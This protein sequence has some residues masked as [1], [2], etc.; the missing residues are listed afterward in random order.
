MKVLDSIEVVYQRIPAKA[1]LYDGTIVDCTVYADPAGE[2]DRSKDKP[3][4]ERY[5]QIMTEGA[6]TYGVK[7]EYI[8]WL[9]SLEKQPRKK[10]EECRTYPVPDG[11][12]FMTMEDVKALNDS[13]NGP[14]YYVIN[15]K[16]LEFHIPEDAEVK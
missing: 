15:N 4:T 6:K 5:I 10:P 16:V 14:M 2:I 13:S 3:P 8:D 9:N 7:Q 11:V 1:K 12:P